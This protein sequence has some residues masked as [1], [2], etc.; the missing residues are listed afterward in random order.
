MAQGCR[1][2]NTFS[3]QVVLQGLKGSKEAVVIT[4]RLQASITSSQ[5]FLPFRTVFL[6]HE[7]HRLTALRRPVRNGG[8]SRQQRDYLFDSALV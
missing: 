3:K 7:R 8:Q 4:M 1:E 5:Q 2:I 6:L